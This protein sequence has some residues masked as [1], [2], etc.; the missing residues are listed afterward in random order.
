MSSLGCSNAPSVVER[1]IIHLVSYV[2][3]PPSSTDPP[4]F[5]HRASKNSVSHKRPMC[6]RLW[7]PG[8]GSRN[9]TP[10]VSG[11][12]YTTKLQTRIDWWKNPQHCTSVQEKPCLPSETFVAKI[13]RPVRRRLCDQRSSKEQTHRSTPGPCSRRRAVP[14]QIKGS[15][16]SGQGQRARPEF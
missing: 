2:L 1:R 5:P 4:L 8:K 6:D 11:L 7:F 9:M 10:Q 15:H 13:C 14:L 16:S 12:F 3:R